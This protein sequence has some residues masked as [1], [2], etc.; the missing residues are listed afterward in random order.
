MG[1]EVSPAAAGAISELRSEWGQRRPAGQLAGQPRVAQHPARRTCAA[2]PARGDP[3]S[4]GRAMVNILSRADL[5]KTPGPAAP[6]GANAR[7]T[8]ILGLIAAFSGG[9]RTV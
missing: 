8:A 1:S 6:L 3:S 2:A 7:D 4:L 5:R 9:V